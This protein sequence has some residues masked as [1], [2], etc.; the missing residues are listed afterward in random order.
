[1][2]KILHTLKISNG[3]K[4][5][6]ITGVGNY[7]SAFVSALAIII[8]SR[9][10]GPSLFG[11]FSVAF[12]LATIIAKL[13]DGGITTATQKYASRSQIKSAVISIVQYGYKLKYILSIVLIIL[14]LPFSGLISDVL[15]IHNSLIIPTS[16]VLGTLLVY[17]DQLVS[18]LLA[19]HSFVKASLVNLT[20]AS[21]KLAT[22][23]ILSFL[24][25]QALFLLIA[26]FLLAP[27]IPFFIKQFFEPKW[28]RTT[29][30]DQISDENKM[31]LLSLAKHSA[32][33]VF[34]MGIIDSIGV[35]FIKGY[36]DSYQAG[37]FGGISRISLL[38]TLIGVSLSQVLNNRVSRYIDK[39]D[40]DAYI[41]KA[42]LLGFLSFFS[43][44]ITLPFIKLIIILTI[45]SE[46]LE[47][48]RALVILLGSVFTYIA[49]V[50]FTA[51]FYSFERNKYFSLS[52]V[53]QILV[54]LSGNF[55][56]VPSFGVIGSATAQ[57]I[58]RFV[59]L[60]FTVFYAFKTY[61]ERFLKTNSTV[62][63]K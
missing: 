9:N 55:L 26:S 13:N 43:F 33:L 11:E 58:S 12:S 56:L 35:L 32:L 17:Y 4:Q 5:T 39:N 48:S 42:L 38:F 54:I 47:G 59:L 16:I 24:Y 19:T 34:V 28:F 52:G 37:I 6:L 30:V 18:S 41:K 8:I 3:I 50:P 36:L 10:L 62:N 44:L 21:F 23:A 51:L 15:Q 57:F 60:L 40:V 2:S 7:I 14:F 63:T 49:S 25:P 22:A 1:M 20:Q 29:K 27:G 61:Q 53:I 45:G 46:Y 31:N